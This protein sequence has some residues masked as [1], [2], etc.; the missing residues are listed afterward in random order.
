MN[1][2][3]RR[4]KLAAAA[5]RRAHDDRPARAPFGF[6]TRVVAQWQDAPAQSLAAVWQRLAWRVLGGV[7]AALAAMIAIDAAFSAPDDPLTPE[8]GNTVSELFWLQ[9]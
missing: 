8:V 7:A 9:Q 1:D 4:W 5:A 3:E 2:F 6:A